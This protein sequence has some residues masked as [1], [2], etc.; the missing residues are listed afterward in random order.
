M[1]GYG[2][3]NRWIT[4]PTYTTTKKSHCATICYIR[5]KSKKNK[6]KMIYARI[7]KDF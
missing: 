2:N 6:R 1:Y 3:L 7:K 4:F 5:L